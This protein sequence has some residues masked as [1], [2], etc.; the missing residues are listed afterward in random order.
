M[1]LIII[2]NFLFNKL[3]YKNNYRI[4]G[5]GQGSER[6]VADQEKGAKP[7]IDF[8]FYNKPTT[9][10]ARLPSTAPKILPEQRFLEHNILL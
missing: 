6:P 5:K 1:K 8:P 9:T 2:I 7:N 3:K 10:L 4:G